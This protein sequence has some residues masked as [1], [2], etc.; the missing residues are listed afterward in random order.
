VLF[1]AQ[2]PPP[3]HGVTAMSLRVKTMMEAMSGLK[4]EHLWF[5]GARSLQDVGKKDLRKILGFARL[6]ARL[7]GR[8]ISGRTHAFSYQT[9]ATHGDA[10]LRDA[11]V[12]AL[13]KRLTS[14]ALVHLHTQG[15]DEVLSC[16]GWRNKF[17]RWSLAGTEL[18]AISGHVGQMAR[19]SGL[20]S[21]VHD[22]PNF[23]EDPK[24]C[25]YGTTDVLRIGYLGNYDPRKGVLRFIDCVAA[26]EAAGV[27]VEARI[28]GGPTKHLSSNDLVAYAKERGVGG[29]IAVLGFV[30]EDEKRQFFD[31]LDLF[32]YPTNHDLAPL[33]V[34]EAMACCTVPIVFDT[35]GL[36]ELVGSGF[37]SNVI[38]QK[39]DAAAYT[40]Q[41]TA[42]AKK[43]WADRGLLAAA[44]RSAREHYLANYTPE[45]YAVR[46]ANILDRAPLAMLSDAPVMRSVSGRG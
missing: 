25:G 8:W 31:W 4:V 41:V 32:V 35:G 39:Q 46:L 29:K 12:I 5:G 30:S 28:A 24:C 23:V 19:S 17:V 26:L 9:L 11:L 15:L 45:I 42:L 20:F 18:I 22:L 44:K 33:V 16:Q 36:R 37:A 13:S 38:T 6:M 43:Y 40:A 21:R 3:L 14:R 1:L 2:L 34:L 10:P 7:S 27:P